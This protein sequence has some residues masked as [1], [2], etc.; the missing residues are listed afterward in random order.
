MSH[1]ASA[2]ILGGASAVILRHAFYPRRSMRKNTLTDM[3]ISGSSVERF[4]R[5]G[6]RVE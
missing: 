5:N 4:G 3:N 2:L 6:A 1:G